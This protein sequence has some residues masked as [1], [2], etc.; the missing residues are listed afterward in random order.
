LMGGAVKGEDR[1]TW[2]VR[3]TAEQ[4]GITLSTAYAYIES[5]ELPAVRL[6]RRLLIPRAAVQ[7]LVDEAM[8]RWGG[9]DV[10]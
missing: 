10:A 4:L 5:G 7:Q 9:S 6:G 2:T 8:D 1:M 3:E